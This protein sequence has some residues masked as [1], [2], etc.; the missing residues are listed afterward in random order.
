MDWEALGF[1]DNPL[2]TDPIKQKTLP[3]YVGH[4]NNV[5]ICSGL[6]A[7]KNVNLVIEGARGVGTTSFANLM[8]FQAK[9]KKHYFTP[10]KEIGVEGGWTIEKLFAAVIANVVRALEFTFKKQVAKDP[11]FQEAK[12]L[13]RRIAEVYR[14]F[15]V[16][17]GAYGVN[18]SMSY[19][20]APGIV[21]QP[22]IVP[23]TILGDHLEELGKITKQL[24]FKNG[25]LI[26]LNNLDVGIIH[27]EEQLRHLLNTLRDYMQIDGV[28]WIL[29]GDTGLRAFISQA[30]DRLDD[31]I[32]HEVYIEPLSE[33][34]FHAL[35][36]RRVEHY[37]INDTVELPIDWSVMSYLHSLTKGRLRYI[38]GLL[39]R[40]LRVLHVGDLTD[41]ISLEVAKPLIDGLLKERIR[42]N[43]LSELQENVLKAVAN[44][45]PCSTSALS[46]LLGKSPSHISHALRGLEDARLIKRIKKGRSVYVHPVFEVIL[47]Y[48][49]NEATDL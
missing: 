38:F 1:Y 23:T 30:V 49:V 48:K 22:M 43:H 24:G 34:A 17:A 36:K 25:L 32:S 14:S 11:A 40:M 28:S 6:L 37:R 45:K 8:R 3:L 15:G 5:R 16:Q 42:Q 35:I 27:D 33:E 29:V 41:K 9:E 47:A 2:D 7:S 12:A 31:I 4:E 19:N 21:T 44:D 10:P 18:A 39:S 20:K 46:T 26:Q 13:S